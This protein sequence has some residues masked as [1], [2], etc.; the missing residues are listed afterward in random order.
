MTLALT[1]M[2]AIGCQNGASHPSQTAMADKGRPHESSGQH[3]YSKDQSG[4]DAWMDD[5]QEADSIVALAAAG[6]FFTT[7]EVVT[8]FGDDFSRVFHR[9]SGDNASKAVRMLEDPTS[10]DNRRIGMNDL[11]E[12]GFLKHETP[13]EKRTAETF[14]KRCRQIAQFDTDFTVRAIAI[15]TENRARDARA[16]A[17]FIQQLNDK[18]ELVRLEAAKALANIPDVN[19]APTLITVMTDRDESRD[20]RV[21]AADALKHYRT[22]P[23]ERALCSA[24]H[25]RSFAVAWQA[26][27][28]LEHMTLRDFQ[29]DEA[30]WLGYFAGEAKAM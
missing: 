4:S 10:A 11:V 6:A 23:A 7:V 21:A 25:D 16:T 2:S 30:A 1:L 14:E 13:I 22:L 29:Y 17:I 12:F 27:R 28:S 18:N 9:F 20:V 15:R 19:A 26:R 24:L 3:H 5:D 8:T